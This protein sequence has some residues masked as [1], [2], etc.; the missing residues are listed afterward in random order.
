MST[1]ERPATR[2]SLPSLPG[3]TA[4]LFDPGRDYPPVADLI[5]STNIADRVDF[6][7]GP[8]IL[9]HEWQHDPHKDPARDV[10]VVESGGR[11][12]GVVQVG[13]RERD[14]K[15]I[16]QLDVLVRPSERRRGIGSALATWGEEHAREMLAED[17][18]GPA[19]LPRF[20]GGWSDIGVPGVLEFT[21][22]RGY[23]PIRYFNLMLRDLA[24]PIP[25]IAM[26]PGLEVRQVVEADH[27][28]IWD[29][30]V[31]AFLDHFEAGVR[32]EEDFVA[33][34]SG[35]DVDTALWQVG[36]DGDEV[37][38]SV[39]TTIYAEEN[40]LLGVERGWLDHVSVRRQWRGRGL[41]SALIAR[42]LVLLRER[43]MAEGALGVDAENPT[44]ALGVYERLGFYRARTSAAFRKPFEEAS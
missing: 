18:G 21:A 3:L 38:G 10:L 15:V 24:L 32:T 44:G 40:A 30:D 8:E 11:P 9:R 35:P 27:R 22:G 20:F 17:R 41:A 29:A 13:W 6:A 39:I 28:R 14:G 19:A 12:V 31:E 36:W 25:D 7:P 23:A 16:H 4:R 1:I 33:F 5:A 37:A 42:T 43:G 2:A 26:P 34:T